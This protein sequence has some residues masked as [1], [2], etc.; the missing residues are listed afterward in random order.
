VNAILETIF[1]LETP[2]GWHVPFPWGSSILG[3][4]EKA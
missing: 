4:F 3:V 2:L 1:S